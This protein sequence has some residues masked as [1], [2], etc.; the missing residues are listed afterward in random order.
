M[1][2]VW[3]QHPTWPIEVSS[4]GHVRKDGRLKRL[5][6]NKSGYCVTSVGGRG[7]PIRRVSRLVLETFVG[8]SDLECRHLDGDRTNNSIKNLKW[9]TRKEQIADQKRIGTFS[10]PP[11]RR[12]HENYFAKTRASD[13]TLAKQLLK[14][15]LSGR[16]IQKVTG[17]DRK[18]VYR[19]RQKQTTTGGR[20][21]E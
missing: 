5:S 17:I 6:I 20:G 1:K 2:E 21:H 19:M 9:G 10:P 15:G 12:E 7:V 18:G 14:K 11:V 8:P 16:E 4:L 3:K 13:W